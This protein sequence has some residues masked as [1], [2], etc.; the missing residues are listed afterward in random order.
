MVKLHMLA[1]KTH[2]LTAVPFVDTPIDVQ[3][4]S[5]DKPSSHLVEKE[6]VTIYCFISIVGSGKYRTHTKTRPGGLKKNLYYFR[7]VV[8]EVLEVWE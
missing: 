6:R 3:G 5:Q 4:A 7:R 8:M 1:W 2:N